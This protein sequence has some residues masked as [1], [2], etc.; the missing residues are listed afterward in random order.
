LLLRE[1]REGRGILQGEE[2]GNSPQRNGEGEDDLPEVT[3]KHGSFGF[4]KGGWP[5]ASR[6][7]PD[8]SGRGARHAARNLFLLGRVLL[9]R[10][11]LD[12]TFTDLN[13]RVVGDADDKTVVLHV[14]DH[15]EDSPGRDDFV[16]GF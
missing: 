9:L 15:A 13:L 14:R 12:E 16:T 2:F 8:R 4:V 6:D 10:D 5:D 3:F 11:G 7:T 1:L